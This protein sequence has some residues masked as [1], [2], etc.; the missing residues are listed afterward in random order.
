MNIV[1][2]LPPNYDEVAKAFDIRGRNGSYVV[3]LFGKR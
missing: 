2:E 3:S 1:N